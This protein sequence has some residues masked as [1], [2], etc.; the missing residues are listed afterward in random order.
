MTAPSTI[1]LAART[2]PR[3]GLAVNVVLIIPRRYSAVTNMTPITTMAISPANVPARVCLIA[4]VLSV[5][6]AISPD[7]DTVNRP[8]ACVNPCA[9]V[10]SALS[11]VPWIFWPAHW[12]AGQRPC[13]LT[14]SKAA[15]AR[16]GPPVEDEPPSDVVFTEY[17]GE[18]ANSPACV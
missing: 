10:G 1:A 8:A 9:D 6:G 16:V 17:P 3:R 12:L 2:R 4:S 15:V 7:P 5:A 13:R 11:V 18:A 14:W